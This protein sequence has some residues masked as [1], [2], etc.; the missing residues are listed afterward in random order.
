MSRSG[1]ADDPKHLQKVIAELI[2]DDVKKAFQS[3]RK[4]AGQIRPFK[5]SRGPNKYLNTLHPKPATG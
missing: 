5:V 2:A 3:Q 1:A 4:T